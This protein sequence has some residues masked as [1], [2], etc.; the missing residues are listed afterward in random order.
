MDQVLS[1][2]QWNSTLSINENIKDAKKFLIKNEI[3]RLNQA[4]ENPEITP[5]FEKEILS[6]NSGFQE[7]L[8]L[9][10]GNPGYVFSFV[11]FM[12]NGRATIEDLRTLY[13][14]IREYAGSLNQLSMSID[15][16]S[17]QKATGEVRPIDALLAEFNM[18]K[19]KRKHGWA[20]EKVNSTLRNNIKSQFSPAEMEKLLTAAAEIDSA[21]EELGPFVDPQTGE[22]STHRKSILSQ[23]NAFEDPTKYLRRLEEYAKGLS[24]NE[25]TEKIS[26]I[27]K[28]GPQASILYAKENYVV[29][30]VRTEDAQVET[31]SLGRWCINRRQGYWRSHG[32]QTEAIQVNIFNY[33]LP[34]TDL[35]H[36]VGTTITNGRITASHDKENN[37]VIKSTDPENHFAGLKYPENLVKSIVPLFGPELEMK[38]LV[39]GA[40]IAGTSPRKVLDSVLLASHAV[41]R[42]SIGDSEESLLSIIREHVVPTIPAEDVV[43]TFS[44]RGIT[45]IPMANIFNLFEG[46]LSEEQRSTV[47]N[48]TEEIFMKLANILNQV[49]YDYNPMAT[50][51]VNDKLKIKES[52]ET[53]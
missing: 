51:I 17:N 33:N 2:T 13:G 20:I 44:K 28:M 12:E 21:D 37:S 4:G 42:S 50:Q 22:Q 53:K 30:S 14:Y 49:G 1:F 23:T 38:K 15:A 3:A 43:D 32:G 34:N 40:G 19:L 11:K 10:S 39:T 31:C 8:Q 47:I 5:D 25:V 29:V 45:S 35:F 9:L 26:E 24:S 27:K 52:L 6:K 16:Y 46:R 7:I 41:N 36:I 18:F 48:K